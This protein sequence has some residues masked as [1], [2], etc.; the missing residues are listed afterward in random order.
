[1]LANPMAE[2]TAAGPGRPAPAPCAA[3][4][5]AAGMYQGAAI[6]APQPIAR[7]VGTENGAL[8]PKGSPGTSSR[9]AT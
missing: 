4:R 1:M 8:M 7:P 6:P 3:S 2:A 5:V 9:T